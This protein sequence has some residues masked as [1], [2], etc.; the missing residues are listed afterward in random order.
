[1]FSLATCK[2]WE[3]LLLLFVLLGAAALRYT[4]LA[5]N[6]HWFTDEATHIDIA[7]NLLAGRQ[8]YQ[9]ITQSTLLFS[10]PPLFEY[11]LAAA[12]ALGF[13][14]MTTLRTLTASLG[15]ITAGLVWL[16]LRLNTN[17]NSLFLPLLAALL[18]AIYPQAILYSRLGFSYNWLSPLVVLILMGISKYLATRRFHWLALAAIAIGLG[19]ISDLWMM[20]ML[21]PLGIVGLFLIFNTEARRRRDIVRQ[22]LGGLGL[23]LLPLAAYSLV[24]TLK[25]PQAFLFDWQFVFLRL[26]SLS[27]AEQIKT[28]AQ[29]MTVLTAQDVWLAAALLGLFFIPHQHLKYTCLL[30]FFIPFIILGR[31]TPLFSL[32]YHYMIPFLPFVAIGLASLVHIA[33]PVIYQTFNGTRTSAAGT[34][35]S[36]SGDKHKKSA[37]IRVHP[38]TKNLLA[39]LLTFVFVITPFW[40]TN[41]LTWEKIQTN[42]PSGITPFLLNPD[43]VREA[44]AYLNQHTTPD[45]IIIATPTIGWLLDGQPADFQMMLAAEQITTPHLPNNIPHDRWAFQPTLAN[46]NFVIIDNWWR[47]WGILHVPQ[48]EEKLTEV[49]DSWLPTLPNRHHHH[50]RHPLIGPKKK[51]RFTKRPDNSSLLFLFYKFPRTTKIIRH[52]SEFVQF[53]SKKK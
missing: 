28:V 11:L 46:A 6:P 26:S 9:A 52:E 37:F 15:I 38:R 17:E 35:R 39:T 41:V 3:W 34:P 13:D 50:L 49:E 19:I 1:M 18:L 7:S 29:N 23:A 24:M 4:N 43:E 2:K 47:N 5:H 53:V 45:D 36:V 22:V 16:T 20:G 32:S 33:T 44:A 10:R 25:A 30:F 31:T 48:L 21:F 14:G 42:W 8:Q 40:Y 12:L 51:G 27:L